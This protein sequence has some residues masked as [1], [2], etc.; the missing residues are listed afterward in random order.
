MLI[1]KFIIFILLKLALANLYWNCYWCI[2]IICARLILLR[3][4]INVAGSIAGSSLNLTQ[5]RHFADA[6]PAQTK[7]SVQL[8]NKWSHLWP[9]YCLLKL[10]KSGLLGPAALHTAVLVIYCSCQSFLRGI[11][12]ILHYLDLW[13]TLGRPSWWVY[14]GMYQHAEWWI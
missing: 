14:P 5:T 8:F 13:A 9:I 1:T 7:V 4:L 10:G 6:P 12:C 11:M 3:F 2:L